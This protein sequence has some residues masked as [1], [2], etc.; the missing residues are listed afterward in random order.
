MYSKIK[1]KYFLFL[2]IISITFFHDILSHFNIFICKLAFIKLCCYNVG[3]NTISVFAVW[4]ANWYDYNVVPKYVF[5]I[6]LNESLVTSFDIFYWSCYRNRNILTT[7]VTIDI[8]LKTFSSK[9]I[10][11]RVIIMKEKEVVF[12]T[13]FCAKRYI[14]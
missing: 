14:Q 8:S 10:L 9:K 3:M 5:F 2:Y 12:K 13:T 4:I 6:Y 7:L 1:Q 11:L